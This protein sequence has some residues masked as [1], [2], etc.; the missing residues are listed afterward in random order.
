MK[1]PNFLIHISVKY[2]NDFVTHRYFTEKISSYFQIYLS[3][4]SAKKRRKAAAPARRC[5]AAPSKQCLVVGQ[6]GKK[7]WFLPVENLGTLGFHG[8]FMVI[9]WWFHGDF[10]VI[11]WWF[12]GDFMGISWDLNDDSIR[13]NETQ[14][15]FMGS[16]W[17]SMGAQWEFHRVRWGF[18]WGF[19]GIYPPFCADFI[20]FPGTVLGF[21]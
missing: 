20:W 6:R 13:L 21:R 18:T 17:N 9:S 8:D 7:R 1:Y 16:W 12:H 4:A 19:N 15:D 14:W 3:A 10:M 5:A 2:P 11:S